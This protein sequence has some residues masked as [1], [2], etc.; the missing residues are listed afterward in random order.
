MQ[1]GDQLRRQ[2]VAQARFTKL[3]LLPRLMHTVASPAVAYLLLV[4]GLCLLVFEFFTA[5]VGVAG[6]VGAGCLVLGCYGVL[7]LPNRPWAFALLLASIL[8]F[9]VDVQTGVPRFWTGVGRRGVRRGVVVPVHRLPDGLADAW[10][11]ASSACSLAFLVGM[12]SMVRTRFATPTIGREWMVGQLGEAAVAVDPEGVVEVRRRA[13]AGPHQ[14]GHA[15]RRAASASA[16][17][18]ST[19]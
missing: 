11:S 5:G 19:A 9:A 7:A 10:P 16:W 6:V 8:C 12:P 14:P 17:W 4:I 18:P 3:D 1:Q 13:V 15:D 2:A